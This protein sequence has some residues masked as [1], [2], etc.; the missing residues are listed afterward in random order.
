MFVPKFWGK[1]LAT[2]F[3]SRM[4]EIIFGRLSFR[5]VVARADPGKFAWI[6]VMKKIGM[7]HIGCPNGNF[8]YEYEGFACH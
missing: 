4:L 1:G 3:G 8:E 7:H 6:K 5:R 2:E